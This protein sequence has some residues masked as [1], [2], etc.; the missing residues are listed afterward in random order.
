LIDDQR[1]PIGW[2]VGRDLPESGRIGTAMAVPMSPFLEPE[3]TLKD[4]LSMLL[5]ADVRAGVGVDAGGHLLGLLTVDDI[6][7]VLD[8]R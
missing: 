3:T 7:A 4:A 5:D 2:I 8:D 1:C 6:S